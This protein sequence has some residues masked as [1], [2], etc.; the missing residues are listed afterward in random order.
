M[1]VEQKR[2]ANE[3]SVASEI[4]LGLHPAHSPTI[5]GYDLIGVSFPCYEVG[6][7]YFDF[8]DRKNVNGAVALGD[9]SGKGT[10]AALLM[11]SLHAAVRAYVT[12]PAAAPQV[13]VANQSI[14]LRQH[15]FESLHYFFLQRA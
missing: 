1:Q 12:T 3:L 15:A 4:Q 14:Y 11:S 7:D 9:V 10:G 8:I 2:L 13:V 6:G 5:E